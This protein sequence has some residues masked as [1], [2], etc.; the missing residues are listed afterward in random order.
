MGSQPGPN[1]QRLS[2]SRGGRSKEFAAAWKI[3]KL[4]E[5]RPGNK[6]LSARMQRASRELL[7]LSCLTMFEGFSI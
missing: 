2:K 7:F 6:G 4:A 3:T 5:S 1:W